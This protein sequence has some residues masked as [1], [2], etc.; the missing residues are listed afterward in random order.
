MQYINIL[1]RFEFQ[2]RSGLSRTLDCRFSGKLSLYVFMGLALCFGG[3]CLMDVLAPIFTGQFRHLLSFGALFKLCGLMAS[4]S[5]AWIIF[6]TQ[7]IRIY[8]NGERLIYEDKKHGAVEIPFADI[9]RIRIQRLQLVDGFFVDLK[10]GASYHFPIT[11]ERLDYVL[12]TLRS[13]RPDI[14]SG[15][16]FMTFRT[17]ALVVDHVLAHNNSFI[18]R[19]HFKIISFYFAYPFFI[20]HDLKRIQADPLQVR[21]DLAY[22]K[23][24]ETIC[25]KANIGISLAALAVLILIK[26]QP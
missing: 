19:G 15:E 20:A 2:G 16:A 17:K 11:I 23:K 6:K 12:D 24:L 26:L 5:I 13:F 4:G 21:R 18:S 9:Q 7:P 14:T 10:S 3:I 25:H 1:N 8:L 22:E